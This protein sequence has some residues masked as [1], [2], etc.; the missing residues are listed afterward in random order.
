MYEVYKLGIRIPWDGSEVEVGIGMPHPEIMP[1]IETEIKAVSERPTHE[2]L[3]TALNLIVE[4]QDGQDRK[5]VS[6]TV[7]TETSSIYKKLIFYI[8]V[9][10]IPK[11]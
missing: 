1:K 8:S 9:E 7:K 6:H 5:I 4:Q 2:I 11:K 3:Q 10:T